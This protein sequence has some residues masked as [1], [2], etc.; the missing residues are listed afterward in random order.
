M[1]HQ[2][3]YDRAFLDSYRPNETFYLSPAGRE[4]LHQVG[5]PVTAG[6]YARQILDR[7]L[8]DLSWNS[9]RLEGNA[10]SLL[11]TTRLLEIGEEADGK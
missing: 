10:Y 5:R 9:S 6:T 4:H 3:G 11:D 8:V 7:L 1:R 2:V